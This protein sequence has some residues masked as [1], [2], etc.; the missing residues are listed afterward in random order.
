MM[1]DYC[2]VCNQPHF[3][4][5]CGPAKPEA[6]PLTYEEVKAKLEQ[7]GV[8]TKA[9]IKPAQEGGI[10]PFKQW[11]SYEEPSLTDMWAKTIEAKEGRKDDSSKNQL[12]LVDPDFIEGVGAVLTA[13]ASKYSRF[14]WQKGINYSRV[15]S[16]TLRHFYAWVK[17][18]TNDPETGLSHLHHCAANLLFLA[19]YDKHKEKY[20]EFDYRNYK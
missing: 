17:G 13:G 9:L 3:P 4:P 20:L 11:Y 16:A 12:D 18:E 8:S 15:I 19:H 2:P 1:K 7:Y 14:N 5:E 6:K 10:A